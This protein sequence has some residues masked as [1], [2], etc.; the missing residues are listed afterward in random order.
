MSTLPTPGPVA[1]GQICDPENISAANAATAA[2]SHLA[3]QLTNHTDTYQMP[4]QF[5]NALMGDVILSP[6][7]GSLIGN[8]LMALSP[9]Q[10]H[11]HSGMMTSNFGQ[12]THCTA[13]QERISAYLNTDV[14]GIPTSFKAA[15]LQY[16]WPGSITQTVDDSVNGAMFRDPQMPNKTYNVGG[17]TPEDQTVWDGGRF[18]LIHPLVVKPMPENEAVARPQLQAAANV[19]I[20]KGATV[21]SNGVFVKNPGCYYS[22]YGYT[23]PEQSAGFAGAADSSAGWAQGASPAVC[24]SFVWLCMKEAKIACVTTN[25]YETSADFTPGAIAGGAAAGSNTLD[26]LFLYSE[27]ERQTAG[28]VLFAELQSDIENQ[29]GAFADVP[30]LGSDVASSLADQIVNDFAFGNPNMPGSSNWQTPGAGNAV[31]PDNITFWNVPCFGYAEPL[32]YLAPH[33]EEYTISKWVAVTQ[34]GALTGT[35][36][37]GGQPAS[38]AYVLLYAGKDA[39]TDQNGKYTLSNVAYGSYDIRASVTQNGFYFSNGQNGKAVAISAPNQNLN[40]DIPTSPPDFRT[41]TM[42]LYL[43][44]DHGDLNP[45]NTHGV[46]YEGPTTMSIQLSPFNIDG[47]TSYSFDYNGGGYFNVQ[48]KI[49]LS[50]NSEFSVSVEINTQIFDDGGNLQ[51]TGA[52]LLFNVA[53]DGNQHAFTTTTETSGTGYH[54]GPATLVATVSNRQT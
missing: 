35:V 32:Q 14:L 9:A 29:E 54:N 8:M 34:Y 47:S 3:C 22:F 43:S 50:L 11:S 37:V 20:G 10:Y 44:C 27:A 26:G 42:T 40:I 51:A 24:S 18:V 30:I 31:S 33:S 5:L 23:L 48:Y 6:A 45:F 38:G 7:N 12:I 41:V 25:K 28:K 53:P 16:L 15:Q 1:A 21:D 36:T 39:Y 2:A 49:S 52:P 46:Q 4:G 17:F 19:A 13:S